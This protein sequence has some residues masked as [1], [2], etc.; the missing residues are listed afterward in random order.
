MSPA[1]SHHDSPRPERKAHGKEARVLSAEEKRGLI[2]AHATKPRSKPS[3]FG[4]YVGIAASC[5]VVTTGWMLTWGHQPGDVPSNAPDATFQDVKEQ[6]QQLK[7]SFTQEKATSTNPSLAEILEKVKQEDAKAK[8]QE[9]ILKTTAK[10]IQ[11]V[12]SSTK[13]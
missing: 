10:T 9:D 5:L 12:T 1:S 4:F 3:A 11:E 7:D 8:A 13:P 6:Y 2:L